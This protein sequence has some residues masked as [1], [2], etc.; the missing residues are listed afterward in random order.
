[1]T[2]YKWQIDE[3]YEIRSMTDN[4]FDPL[5]KKYTKEFFDDETQVFRCGSFDKLEEY[6]TSF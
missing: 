5:F 3:N 4:E 2:N 1:M 6:L